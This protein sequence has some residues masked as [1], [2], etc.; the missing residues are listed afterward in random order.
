MENN[1]ISNKIIRILI[2]L[3][4]IFTIM[5]GT[6]AYLSWQTTS[7]QR[8]Q[9]SFT[10]KG[11]FSCSAISDEHIT[12]EGV[13]LIPS[14]CTN[15]DHVI[16]KEITTSVSN[17]TGNNA[18][19]SM[20]LYV[21]KLG[22]YLSNSD[23]FKYTLTNNPNSC[24]EE[25]IS[26]GNFK[27][28]ETGKKNILISGKDFIENETNTYYLWIW[29]DKEETQIPPEDEEA[30]KFDFSLNG[31]CSDT[32]PDSTFEITSITNNYQL[33]NATVVNSDKNIVSY[34][35]T[36]DNVEPVFNNFDNVYVTPLI[37]NKDNKLSKIDNE[38]KWIDIPI[39]DQNK[40]YNFEYIVDTIGTYYIWFKDSEGQV[41]SDSVNVSQI[42]NE[43]PIC[44]FSEFSNTHINIEE[45]TTINLTCIDISSEIID[46]DITKED[47]ILSTNSVNLSNKIEKESIENGYKYTLTLIGIDTLGKTNLTLK[48]NVIKNIHNN[49]NS[50]ITSNDIMVTGGTYTITYKDVGNTEF[51]GIHE[52]EY[53]TEYESGINT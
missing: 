34:A 18:Y 42:Y 14:D 20:W 16:K 38:T 53:P 35:V 7:D 26:S 17:L 4:V 5:G 2:V 48:E 50:S 37:N 51:S 33:I 44:N 22:S 45:T 27:D 24:K 25:V 32:Q 49:G 23:N 3:S 29:L 46:S 28:L 36:N 30:L 47:I 39:E 52:S 12:N 15:L 43:G 19:L 6:F 9:I 1:N 10:A 8:T 40:I 21:N 11:G 31:E 41:I 13:T